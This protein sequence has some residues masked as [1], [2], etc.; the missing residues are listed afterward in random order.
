MFR[1]IDEP[2]RH[3]PGGIRIFC[4][5]DAF[6]ERPDIARDLEAHEEARLS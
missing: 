6:G 5:F 4:Q 2:E 1:F 3:V